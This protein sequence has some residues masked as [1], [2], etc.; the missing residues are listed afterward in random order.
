MVVCY[1]IGMHLSRSFSISLYLYFARRT[2]GPLPLALPIDAKRKCSDAFAR[3][4]MVGALRTAKANSYF[5][6]WN[7][8][9][10]RCA[11]HGHESQRR[12]RCV[13]FVSRQ[14]DNAAAGCSWL[15]NWDAM[16]FPYIYFSG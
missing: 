10:R 12:T 15:R 3:E 4:L 8:G 16:N 1:S 5:Y 6:T 2:L 11:A 13:A 9:A 14:F 7:L